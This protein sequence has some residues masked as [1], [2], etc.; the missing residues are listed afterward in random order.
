VRKISAFAIFLTLFC[1]PSY[2]LASIFIDDIYTTDKGRWYIEFSAD[3][4]RDVEQG[5]DLE[6]GENIKPASREVDAS[7]YF[8]YGLLDNLDIGL[9]VPYLFI[10]SSD[11]KVNGFSDIVVETKYRLRQESRILPGFALYFDLKAP[12]ANKAKNLGTGR[13]D[14]SINNIFTKNIGDNVFDLNLGYVFVCSEGEDN[15]FFYCFDIGRNL[16]EKIG[17]CAEIYGENTFKGDFDD[18]ILIG[19]LSLSYEFNENV[20]FEIGAGGG[21]SKDSP[22][23][24]FSSTIT[25]IF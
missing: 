4:Y 24:Q 20:Y 7:A 6:S 18:N 13:F 23:C 5:F 19:A 16:T 21:I 3:Y 15:P 22:D 1:F 2:S 25:F 9:T 10:N 11:G 17:I 8:S 14:L 12:S